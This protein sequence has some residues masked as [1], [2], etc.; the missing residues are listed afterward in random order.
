[1]TVSLVIAIYDA[2]DY[3]EERGVKS[4]LPRRDKR[5]PGRREKEVLDERFVR[6]LRKKFREQAQRIQRTLEMQFPERKATL[7][8]DL[9]IFDDDLEDDP[10]IMAELMRIYRD[11]IR[12]G[13]I[14]YADK[15]AIGINYDQVNYRLNKWI[16][17]YAYDLIRE[18]DDFTKQVLKRAIQ[19]FASTP[20]FTIR[21]IM[22]QLPF[23]DE[24]AMRVAVTEITR[25]FAKTEAEAGKELKDNYPDVEVVKVW[26]T[27]RDDLV[28]EICGPLENLE[29]QIDETFYEPGDYTDGDP[30]A[31]PNCRC[32]IDTRTRI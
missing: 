30:P 24:R 31:H 10:E 20:G 21:D 29:I 6:L 27:N 13:L 11:A 17:N 23:T 8:I 4:P 25:A 5:E 28:C 32:W 18:I 2:C 19:D 15:N 26:Y 1:M 14:L 7:P 22:D 12:R 16:N 9:N 3:L